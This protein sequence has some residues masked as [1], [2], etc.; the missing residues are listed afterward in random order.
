MYF[1]E[2]ITYPALLFLV[3]FLAGCSWW[4][5]KEEKIDITDTNFSVET[6]DSYFGLMNCIIENDNS[7]TYTEEMRNEL[8]KRIKD[9]QSDWEW[10][11]HDVLYEKCKIELSKYNEIEDRLEKI[12]CNKRISK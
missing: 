7:E 4:N 8:K 1:M 9:I 5:K 11:N 2:K 10:L 6:C 3:I 12:W